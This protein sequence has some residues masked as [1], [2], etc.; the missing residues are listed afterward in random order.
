MRSAGS[1]HFCLRSFQTAAKKQMN[2]TLKP[3]KAA[4]EL[5]ASKG[6]DEKYGARPLKRAL[7]NLV[8]DPLS[9]E[10]LSG[11]VSSG[12]IVKVGCRDEKITFQS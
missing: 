1:P 4:R 6:F 10:I 5:I 8:E 7:Q 12:D 11:R 2:I 3:N 9:E